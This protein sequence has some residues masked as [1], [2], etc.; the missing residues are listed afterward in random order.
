M[1][2]YVEKEFRQIMQAFHRWF[3]FSLKL[4]PRPRIAWN[5]YAILSRINKFSQAEFMKKESVILL[6]YTNL[7]I[8]S[9]LLEKC[10]GHK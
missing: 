4:L 8:E 1:V 2:F 10:D 3:G 5:I 9:S 7:F 6:K